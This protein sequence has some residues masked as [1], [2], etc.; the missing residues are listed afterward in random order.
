M[1]QRRRA[2]AWLLLLL[3]S[4]HHATAG[5]GVNSRRK[6]R[7]NTW[8]Q[9]AADVATRTMTAAAEML[10]LSTPPFV[11][12]M[13]KPEHRAGLITALWSD[14]LLGLSGR[15]SADNSVL[16]QLFADQ[17]MDDAD[18]TRFRQLDNGPRFENVIRSIFRSRSSRIVPLETAA[19][20]IQ[21][22]YYKVPRPVW[23]AM[24]YYSRM[25]M[26]RS[27][28]ETLCDDA[29]LCDPGPQYPVVRGITAAVFDNLRMCVGYGSYATS[30]SSGYAIDMTNWA[31]VFMPASAAPNSD[32]IDMDAMLGQGGIFR[33]DVSLDEFID[34]FSPAAPDILANQRSRWKFHLAAAANGI[35]WDSTPFQSPYPPTRFHFHDPIFDRLQS[36]YADVNFELNVMRRSPFH[37]F[38][39]AIMLGGDGLSYMRVIHRLSQNARLFLETKPIVIPRFGENPHGRFH[40]MHGDW[41]VWAPLLMRLAAVV[42]NR[43][44]K[45]DPT[46]VD[47]N[48]HEHSLRIFTRACAEYVVEIARTGTDYT[49]TAQFLEDADRNLSFSYVV[50][51]LYLF[52]FKYLEYR[53]AGR[54]NDSKKLDLLW[55]ENLRTAKT[56]KA[57]KTNYRQ[58]SIILIYWGCVLLEPLQ[59]FY[60]N[61]RTLRWIHSHV[62][63]DMPIEKLNMWLKEAVISQITESQIC[64]FIRRLNFTQHVVRCIKTIVGA[65]R[66]P[67]HATLKNIDH[68]VAL[69]KEFLRTCIGTTYRQCTQDS[70]ANLLSVDMSDWGGL[71]RPRA[72]AP[73]RQLRLSMADYRSYVRR[74]VAKLCPWHRWRP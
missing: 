50:Y 45:S 74:Q 48:S 69:M 3:A 52:A 35:I 41:R 22:L 29:V 9:S 66:Q 10:Q 58:M 32:G 40:I 64:Q 13:D 67:E 30:Q 47:F 42:G 51:F 71:R 38:S 7:T 34:L 33:T 31:T 17:L 43:Q 60:H 25:V 70:D 49:Q 4:V 63:W 1:V 68:D 59:T 19:L 57:N 14:D 28:V 24:T 65:N 2:A 62:G 16:A 36:S 26:S 6:K 27:W 72:C 39:D 73:H 55:R 46:V 18:Q 56:A 21:W 37:R 8:A 23:S 5:P 20:S 61:T 12:H 54:T 53:N 44:V 11:Y 15:F